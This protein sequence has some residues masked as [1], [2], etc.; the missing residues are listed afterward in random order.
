MKRLQSLA[1]CLKLGNWGLKVAEKKTSK[2]R[3]TEIQKA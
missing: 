1:F 3:N 2:G